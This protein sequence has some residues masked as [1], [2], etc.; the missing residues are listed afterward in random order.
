MG[1][2][3]LEVRILGPVELRTADGELRLAGR[4]R[5]ALV[6]MLALQV[7]RTVPAYQL[8]DGMWGEDPPATAGAQVRRQVSGLRGVL[9]GD[10]VATDPGGY[11]LD[12]EPERVDA[13][14]H[15]RLVAGARAAAGAGDLVAAE[16]GLAAAL[17]LWRG[18]ALADLSGTYFEAEAAR[19]EESRL[20]VQEEYTE[21]LL[22]QGQHRDLIG[23]LTALVMSHPLRERPRAQLMLALYQ[24]GRKA[25]ALEVYRRGCDLLADELGLEPSAEVAGLHE[26]M[27]RSD[28][29]LLS[30]PRSPLPH[31]RAASR[32]G[33]AL[34]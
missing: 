21:L 33:A 1:D 4:L 34:R 8:I 32:A 22:G 15:E 20:A 5:R 25:E 7:N 19:L 16:R 28:P 3:D 26:A 11:R 2:C 17:D 23:E 9:G 24:A 12:I 18:D 31:S 30:A 14:A 29:E 10:V 13:R 6:G 27:L